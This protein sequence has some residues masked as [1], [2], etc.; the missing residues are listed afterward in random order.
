MTSTKGE[1]MTSQFLNTIGLGGVDI[2]YILLGMCVLIL[3]LLI[4]LIVL[5]VKT[6]DLKKRYDAFMQGKNAKSMEK[7][8]AGVCQDIEKLKSNTDQHHRDIRTLFHNLEP[9]F[10][11]VGVVRYDAFQQISGKLSYVVA[12]LDEKDNG[13]ILNSVYGTESSYSYIKEIKRGQFQGDLSPEEKQALEKAAGTQ[14]I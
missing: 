3:I 11:K 2:G 9:A 10:Q 6:S 1:Y 14:E 5:I 8:I 12:L 4:L 13:F 7:Q